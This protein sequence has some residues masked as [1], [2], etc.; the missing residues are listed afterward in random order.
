MNKELECKLLME[1]GQKRFEHSLRVKDVALN[2]GVNY[3]LEKN[4]IEAAAILHDCAKINDKRY[5]LKRVSDFDIILDNSMKYNE[6][7]IHGPLGAKIAEK[8][9]GIKNKDVLNAI[10]FHTTGRENMSL[11]EKVIYLA[12]YIEPDRKFQGL[13]EIRKLS[14][15][16]L[17]KAI[18]LTMEKT[19]IYL[20]EKNRIIHP[21]TIKARNYLIMKNKI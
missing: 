15:I 10:E 4:E 7:L 17:D 8:E 21:N 6:E 3:G 9:Y 18:I 20:I 13:D 1:I 16:D 14:F 19:M 11:L 12:D 5:L 2:L